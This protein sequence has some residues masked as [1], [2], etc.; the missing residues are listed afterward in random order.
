M[1]VKVAVI[2][3]GA[4]GSSFLY[5]AIHQ[6]LAAEFGLIDYNVEFA[7]GQAL[8]L[9]DSTPYLTA[10]ARVKVIDYSNLKDYDYIVI[11]AGRPQKEGETRLEMIKDNAN[12]MKGI[13]ENVKSSGFKGIVLICS[14]PVDVLTYVF[15]K[16]TGFPA[17]KV[18]GSGT[19]LDSARLR[20]EVSKA[21]EI[22]TASLE[23]AFVIGEHGDSSLVTFSMMR[24]GG[25]SLNSCEEVSY[26]NSPYCCSDY[27]EKL[28]K[29]V[30]RKAYEIINRK[31]ATHYGIG[32]A[33]V[34]ILQAMIFDKNEILPVSA[35]LNGEYGVSDVV[36]GAPAMIN[37]DGIKKVLEFPLK[38]KELKKFRSSAEIL[39]KNIDLIRD[40][41]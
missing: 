2:G 32:A 29:V 40:L 10:E 33:L 14:N 3:C 22:P 27:E 35:L 31:R 16:V 9:E 6:N 36:I 1:A 37:K 23:G 11:T 7:R 20:L 24:V 5:S 18:V 21:L 30:Y 25:L 39:S 8:D 13:A 41:I 26:P 34:K 28:E 17:N 15:Q 12:I 4:V 38:E 19:V